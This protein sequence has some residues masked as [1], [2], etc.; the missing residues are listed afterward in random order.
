[1]RVGVMLDTNVGAVGRAAPSRQEVTS[2]HRWSVDCGRML[3][4]TAVDGVFVAERH[5]RTDCFSPAPLEQLAALAG[6]TSRLRLGTYVLMPP[7]YPPLGLLERLAVVDHLSGGRLVCGFGAGYHPGYATVHGTT[8]AGR[9]TALD[10]F[11]DLLHHGWAHGSVR[12]D[13]QEVYL[14]PP[15]QHPRPPV[16]I[17]GISAAAV[18]RAARYGDAFAIGFT[19]RGVHDVIGGYR[20]ACAERGTRPRLVLIQS[21]WVR[22]GVDARAECLS[23]LVPTLGPEMTLYQRHGQVRADGD[24]TAERM[25]P[26]LYVGDPDEVVAHVRADV[27]RFGVDEVVLR[28]HIGVPPRDA[29]ADCLG[30]IAERVA[31]ALAADST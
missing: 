9:G 5:G 30:L 10:R 7:L 6:V 25:L 17:G 22:A 12:V 26:Y 24:I 19:D 29:V 1:M 28:V 31:P 20:A 11:L 23:Y 27:T 4:G 18:R 21:A 2:F 3:D 8:M 16:W 15:A 14:V 13:G